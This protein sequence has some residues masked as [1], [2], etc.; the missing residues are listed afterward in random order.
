VLA[1]G[2]S[3]LA[4]TG[5]LVVGVCESGWSTGVGVRLSARVVGKFVSVNVVVSEVGVCGEKV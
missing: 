2:V 1:D 3:G 5:E 4:G